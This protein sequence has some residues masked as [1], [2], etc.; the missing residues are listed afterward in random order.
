M[1]IVL[2]SSFFFY[3]IPVEGELYTTP[4]VV[5]ELVDIR[6]KGQFEKY[7]ALGLRVV[8][9]DGGDLLRVDEASRKTGDAGLISAT[10]RELLALTL[11]LGPGA[12]L[13]TDDFAIQNVAGKLGVAVAPMQQ[14]K[15]KQIRW[16]YRCSGCRKFFDHDGE[17]PVCG[18]EIKRKLK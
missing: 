13:Y 5:D 2:D 7:C 4:S 10:D 3:D 6:S 1:K 9:P 15:A 12:V 8:S 17:C 11:G 16:R 14:R 18:S